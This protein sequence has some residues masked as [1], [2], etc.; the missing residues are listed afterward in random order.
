MLYGL[1]WYKCLVYVENVNVYSN[2][3]E[4]HLKR[5]ERR[6]AIM[7]HIILARNMAKC[8]IFQVSVNSLG[9]VLVQ[10]R[11]KSRIDEHGRV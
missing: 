8:P 3:S 11:I 4:K 2:T 6:P 10:R 1:R 7:K 5:V 9:H